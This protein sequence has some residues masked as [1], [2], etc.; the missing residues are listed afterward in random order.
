MAYKAGWCP[1]SLIF[2]EILDVFRRNCIQFPKWIRDVEF[3]FADLIAQ[4][5][6][7][8]KAIDGQANIERG[9]VGYNISKTAVILS[10]FEYA[11]ACGNFHILR[12]KRLIQQSRTFAQASFGEKETV[13]VNSPFQGRFT[14]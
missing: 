6:E 8:G 5:L 7:A 12:C 10:V 9:F 14:T 1:Y 3:L 11:I 4:T 13:E 2:A